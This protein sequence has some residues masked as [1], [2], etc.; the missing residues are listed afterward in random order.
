MATDFGEM[1]KELR[2]TTFLTKGYFCDGKWFEDYL[3][4]CI[5]KKTG[6]SDITMQE[7]YDFSG[8]K[9]VMNTVLRGGR[10]KMI[11]ID[12][13]TFPDLSL[14]KAIRMTST[15]PGFLKPLQ[16]DGTECYDGGVIDN[17]LLSHYDPQ[18]SLGIYLG[19]KNVDKHANP[20]EYGYTGVRK[21]LISELGVM[22]GIKE[23]ADVV[24]DLFTI[25][26]LELERIRLNGR[27]YKEIF[28]EPRD[29]KTLSIFIDD[30]KKR[31]M[32]VTGIKESMKFIAKEYGLPQKDTLV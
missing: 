28:V 2:P 12:H 29:V 31:Q 21:P 1:M 18:E 32:I 27:S 6:K 13:E 7:L 4:H 9:L 24:W 8:I 16:I 20:K 23:F 5:E 10:G 30:V 25:V 3:S 15:I 11:M 19:R 26:S 14:I 17:Y 22:D